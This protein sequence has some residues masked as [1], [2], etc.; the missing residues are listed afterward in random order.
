MSEPGFNVF[1]KWEFFYCLSFFSNRILTPT[2]AHTI[3]RMIGNG[4]PLFSLPSKQAINSNIRET[5]YKMIIPFFFICW[6][7]NLSG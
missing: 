4:N 7:C 2:V 1:D 5:E 6:N 3:R